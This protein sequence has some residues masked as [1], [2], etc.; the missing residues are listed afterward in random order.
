MI[1]TRPLTVFAAVSAVG[2]LTLHALA[3]G[4]KLAKRLC[5]RDTLLRQIWGSAPA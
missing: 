1:A 2:P 4:G 3:A 5:G